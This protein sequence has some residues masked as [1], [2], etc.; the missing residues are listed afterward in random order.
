M[1]LHCVVL[2]LAICGSLTGCDLPDCTPPDFEASATRKETENS[3]GQWTSET[4][5]GVKAS[6]SCSSRSAKALRTMA[7]DVSDIAID[8][9]GQGT[10]V[11]DGSGTGTLVLTEGGT[12]VGSTTFNYVVL[13]SMA[14]VADPATLN[15]W[16]THYPLADGY[17]V[18]LHDIPS[19]DI[20]LGTATLTVD[21]YYGSTEISTASTS[22]TSS[23]GSGC[24]PGGNHG[25][26]GGDQQIELPGDGGVGCP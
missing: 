4:T 12:V 23:A 19:V 11:L 18:K 1:K 2:A 8:I 3:Q 21:A 16:L 26:P 14:V 5:I 13:D 6:I 7:L 22:W 9:T 24:I 20:V 10:A 15:N 25:D 17:D